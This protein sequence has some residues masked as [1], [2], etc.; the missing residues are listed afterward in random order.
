[1]NFHKK[2]FWIDMVLLVSVISMFF[3][4]PGKWGDALTGF[5][6]VVFV[7]SIV[8]HLRNY[9]SYKKFY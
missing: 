4:K 9:I 2:L 8:N 7:V 5:I 1:M 3:V 6:A